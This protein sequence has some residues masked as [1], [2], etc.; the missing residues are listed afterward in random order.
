MLLLT[1][2]L[3]LATAC[4]PAPKSE[5]EAS[6]PHGR[7]ATPQADPLQAPPSPPDN[8]CAPKEGTAKGDKMGK[9][10][11]VV[12][13][14]VSGSV[15]R[16]TQDWPNPFDGKPPVE[17][18]PGVKVAI[19]PAGSDKAVAT[20]VSAADGSY[21]FKGLPDGTYIVKVDSASF[22][23]NVI[24]PAPGYGTALLPQGAAGVTF[25]D[26]NGFIAGKL[27]RE[28]TP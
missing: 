21:S 7:A 10:P 1:G 26:S 16:L 12:P 5:T 11:E 2:I 20:A 15:T 27:G 24:Q 13:G 9:A 6:K 18:F 8:P 25:L 3:V 4:P 14:V 17:P 22:K 28:K 19:Y 23:G